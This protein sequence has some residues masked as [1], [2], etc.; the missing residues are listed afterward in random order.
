LVTAPFVLVVLAAISTTVEQVRRSPARRALVESLLLYYPL[1]GA[2]VTWFAQPLGGGDAVFVACVFG[3]SIATLEPLSALVS[4][5]IS[6]LLALLAHRRGL[7]SPSMRVVVDVTVVVSTFLAFILSRMFVSAL[8]RHAA[9]VVTVSHSNS[10]IASRVASQA[11]EIAAK[12]AQIEKLNAEL[13]G[14]LKKRSRELSAALTMLSQ[15]AVTPSMLIEGVIVSGRFVVEAKLNQ[16]GTHFL[17]T[18]KNTQKRVVLKVAQASSAGQL[19]EFQ[20]FLRELESL[21]AVRNPVLV[22]TVFVDLA[23]DGRL[24]HAVDYVSGQTLHEWRSHEPTMSAA[25]VVRLGALVAD[26]LAAAH[27][28]GVI[29]RDIKPSNLLLSP[30][31]PGVRVIEFAAARLRDDATRGR[32][33]NGNLYGTPEYMAPELIADG[34]T[35]DGKV[36]VYSLGTVLYQCLSGR[37]PHIAANGAGWLRAHTDET[38][39]PLGAIARS[40]PE[41]LS[42]LIMRCLAKSPDERP[43]AEELAALFGRLCTELDAP[44]LETY[45]RGAGEL[46]DRRA[47]VKAISG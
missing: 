5:M 28:K 6:M 24:F 34:T 4:L 36:D 26:A 40:I 33:N 29:H 9:A 10:Q 20:R 35:V 43:A 31:S 1:Y 14:Q 42:A 23:E 15:R 46:R 37:L 19:D 2:A 39:V 44:M 27:A 12:V 13:N 16:H 21:S 47:Q 30:F 22:K 38:P 11:T 17:A 18:D 41:A 45:V 7:S 3:S 32:G 25:V 8:A